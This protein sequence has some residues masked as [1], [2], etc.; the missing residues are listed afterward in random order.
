MGTI[1]DQG[2]IDSLLAA[3][4]EEAAA[5]AEAVASAA[6]TAGPTR[7]EPLR[8]GESVPP[9]V[10]R[11]LKI[12][13]PLIVQLARQALSVS[14]IRKLSSGTILEFERDV[15]RPCD[16]LVNNRPIGVGEVVRVG[17]NFGL[18]VTEIRDAAARIRSL[19]G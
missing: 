12:R 5:E 9:Q 8:I 10:A 16:L 14:R 15:D 13:V 18:R 11:L 1:V 6:G 4:R 3:A 19:G 2:Q 17:E 7:V